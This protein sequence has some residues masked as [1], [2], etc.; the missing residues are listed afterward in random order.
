MQ[1]AV[2]CVGSDYNSV[3]VR[4]LLLTYGHPPANTKSHYNIAAFPRSKM[5][6]KDGH[7]FLLM[8]KITELGASY[9]LE[10]LFIHGSTV[11]NKEYECMPPQLEIWSMWITTS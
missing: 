5:C 7:H 3:E 6:G 9:L 11:Y 1:A 8:E 2:L 10:V 4:N